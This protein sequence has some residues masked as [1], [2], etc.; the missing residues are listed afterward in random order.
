MCAEVF[1]EVMLP[2]LMTKVLHQGVVNQD[3]VYIREI[4]GVMLLILAVGLV[5]GITCLVFAG[6]ASQSAGA[7]IRRDLFK[8]IQQFSYT[9]IDKY[10]PSS[11]IT[12][13]TNDITQVQTVMMVSMRLLVRAPLL[14]IGSIVMAVSIQPQLSLLILVMVLA[15]SVVIT[16]MLR[17]GFPAFR[18]VQGKLDT[19]NGVM[20][21]NLA[22]LRVVRAFVKEKYEKER[23]YAVNKDYRDTSL[24]AYGIMITIMPCMVVILNCTIVGVLW[25]GAKLVDANLLLVEE[26]MA[27]ITYLMQILISLT[28][29]AM[30]LMLISR[31]KVSLGRI[32]EILEEH[33]DIENPKEC[34]YP[35]TNEGRVEYRHVYFQ[36][37]KEA[38]EPVLKDITFTAEPGE[39]IGILSQT[40][41]GKS[42]LVQ[43]MPRLYDVSEGEVFIDGINVKDY[44]LTTLRKKVAIV[45][46]E[47]ILF[48]G[49]IRENICWGSPN[50]SEEEMIAAA[51]SAQA[52]EFI[53]GLQDGY[54]T[55]IGQNGVNLS[56]GQKQRVSIA[57]TLLLN[58]SVLIFDDSTS[59]VDTV[60]E[61][62]I[63]KAL[64]EMP[65]TKFII[66]QRISSI[67]H[68]DK[69]MLLH[70]GRIAALGRHEELMENS[71][72][73][74]DIYNSQLERE[75]VSHE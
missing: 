1:S 36:Y 11:F 29:I 32:S 69:I 62:K 74:R 8:K 47:T 37:V 70:Q 10:K 49:T 71:Q 58:P 3:W 34:K 45:L 14:C 73:Y 75:E 31:G 13:L 40:G 59:A 2:K 35:N 53:M 28:M 30:S 43:L 15:V 4:I 18:Q 22:G 33:I 61:K 19:V 46:Q 24:H 20:R 57:R 12:R 5:G 68:A 56:G 17:K 39:T 66:A 50:A 65:C 25:F 21:E 67:Q 60:T 54:D 23:F 64:K 63:Q 48:S 51:K 27:Y 6:K 41:A 44:D 38:K 7:D 72:E 55:V 42:T 16:I 26:I 9:N 52:H